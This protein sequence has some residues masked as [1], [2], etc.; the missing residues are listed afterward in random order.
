MTTKKYI[1]SFPSLECEQRAFEV[2]SGTGSKFSYVG[3][4]RVE[5]TSTQKSVLKMQGVPLKMH[6]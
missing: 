1:V 2:L 4:R 6:K 3:N 5:I